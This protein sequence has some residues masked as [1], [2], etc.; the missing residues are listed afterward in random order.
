MKVER[1]RKRI[2]Q[3]KKNLFIFLLPR[4]IL[5]YSKMPKVER[6]RKRIYSFFFCRDASYLIQRCRKSSGMQRTCSIYI[7]E[8]HPIL[9]K[10]AESRAQKKKNLFI[11]LLPRRILS[12]PKI[13]K[14]ERN[15]KSLLNLHSRDAS[16]LI[17]RYQKS[18]GMQRACSICI[19]ET[20]PILSK[21]SESQAECKELVQFAFPRR[22][23]S[24]LLHF[25]ALHLAISPFNNRP[26]HN[27]P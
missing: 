19:P 13:P 10:D 14:V 17:Q 3:K 25:P 26:I 18:S 12:Y 24:Y 23:L 21:D 22:I 1:R 8:T 16:Y 20:H 15:A 11:F 2:S 7:P 5:S 9:F 27:F 4:R 6:R